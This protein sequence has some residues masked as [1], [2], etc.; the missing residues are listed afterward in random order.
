MKKKFAF[1]LILITGI[2]LSGC[3]YFETGEIQ[4]V[5]MLLDTSI[6]ASEWSEKGYNGLLQIGE[7]FDT[8][9]YYKENISTSE[10]INNAVAE[11]VEDGVN[12]VYGHSS[13]YGS[14]FTEV[15]ELYPDVHF[16]YFNGG[17]YADNVTSLNFNSHAMGFLGGMVAGKMTTSDLA[18]II[19]TYNWQPEIEGFYEGVKYQNPDAEILINYVNDWKDTETALQIYE[20][21]K[22]KGVDIFYPI[23]DAYS[24]EVIQM[25]E[26]DGLYAIGYI[27]D[28]LDEAPDAVLTSTIQHV[29]K[30]YK[31]TA[32]MFNKNKLE[33]TVLTFDF[34]DNFISLGGFN[35]DVPESFQKEMEGYVETYIETDLLPN[36]Q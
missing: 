15:A 34:Q 28:Q 25:A 36:E 17:S 30:L 35:D 24:N 33:G 3:S 22:Q 19:A 4:N 12:L 23:G 31:S 18:G 5:G 14:Y 9:V 10:E 29:D 32:E 7:E 27:S 6:E 1:V 21:M 2:A 8:D 16:V 20:E 11:F 13:I 26:E